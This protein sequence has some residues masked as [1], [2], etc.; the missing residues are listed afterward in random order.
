MIGGLEETSWKGEREEGREEGRE[1]EYRRQT[2]RWNVPLLPAVSAI[3]KAKSG[4]L[5]GPCL[6]CL[7]GRKGKKDCCYVPVCIS[8]SSCLFRK[9]ST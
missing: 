4:W 6:R 2:C 1:E 5:A 7:D 3:P 8:Y 9:C